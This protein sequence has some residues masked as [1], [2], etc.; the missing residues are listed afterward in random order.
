MDHDLVVREKMTERYLLDELEAGVRDEF[1]E[2]FFTCADCAEDVRAGA[3]LVAQSKAILADTPEEAFVRAVPSA[4]PARP[5]FAW[6]RPA[7]AV[8]V[9][10]LLLLLVGYQNLVVFP[11]LQSQL[12]QPQVLPWASVNVG[13]WGEGGPAI[14]VARGLGFLLFVRIPPDGN[15]VRYT[16]DLYNHEGKLE[17]SFTIPAAAGQDQWPVQIPSANRAAGAYTLDVHG[18]TAAGE[19]KEIGKTSFQ[20]NIQP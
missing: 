17:S 10:A 19:R 16:A 3:E 15:Y 13:T 1:E 6:L 12:H 20:L 4:K 2:H 7:F 18:V 5:W 9:M 8:P 11:K 14:T